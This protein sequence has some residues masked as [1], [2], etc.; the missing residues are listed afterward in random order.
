MEKEENKNKNNLSITNEKEGIIVR[1]EQDVK[2]R[3]KEEER[4]SIM[5]Y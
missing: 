1:K 2:R 5:N 3:T 4:S